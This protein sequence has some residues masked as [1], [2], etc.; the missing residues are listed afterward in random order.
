MKKL[1][2]T[3]AEYGLGTSTGIDLPNE[4]TGYLPDKFTFANYLTNSFGQFDNL[5][6]ASAGP[7]CLNSS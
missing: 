2:S 4:S 1:R 5:Y 3:F 7:V 6:N